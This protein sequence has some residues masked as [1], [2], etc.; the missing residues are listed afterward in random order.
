MSVGHREVYNIMKFIK[1]ILL[2]I[3][4][5]GA[6]FGCSV[7]GQS[8]LK[9]Y[10]IDV[11]T[12]DAALI[13]SPTNKYVL[14]DAGDD[15]HNYGDTVLRF[16]R[17]LGITHLDHIIAS[18]YHQD[19]IGG[20]PR[21]IYGL[22]GANT[23]DSILGWCYDR[24]D[25]YTTPAFI[26]YKNAIGT[27]RRTIGLGETLNLGGG[28][29]MFCVA[30]NGKIMN[31]DSVLPNTEENYRSL[32]WVIK[33]GRFRFYTGG[34]LVGYNVSGERDVETKVA[35]VI[36]K[37]DV[38]KVN[39]HGSR[40]SSNPTFLDSLRPKAAIISQGVHP[41]NNNHPHQEAL[42]R[43]AT[44]N[45]YIYQMNTNP[46][47]GTIPTGHGRIL[48]TTATIIVNRASY[49]INGDEYL[50]SGVLRDG[51]CLSI[52]SPPDTILEQSII[53]PK[54]LIKNWGNETEAFRIRF[55]ITPAYNRTQNIYDLAPND[56]MT[57]IFDTAWYAI[58]GVYQ[59]VCSTE[60]FG[61]TNQTNDKQTK[62][63]V[64]AFYDSEITD[65]LNPITN[66]AYFLSETITPTVIV[67][68][69]SEYAYPSSVK[70]YC[71]IR[72]DT[73]IYSD[74]M[75]ILSFPGRS[76]TITFTPLILQGLSAGVY[77]CSV[78]VVRDVD[79]VSAN[80][81][82]SFQFTVLNPSGISEKPNSVLNPNQ[83]FK[84][85]ISKLFDVSGRLIQSQVFS[86]S[87]DKTNTIEYWS[88]IIPQGI[89]FLHITKIPDDNQ[90]PTKLM[91]KL[92]ILSKK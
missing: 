63:L 72:N 86:T 1:F 24:G 18:H 67:K 59:V 32:V 75:E 79:L 82:R 91:R 20:I 83:R 16:L 78:A 70:V 50:L 14:I 48:N 34:D 8:R 6:N 52:L 76:D 88:K 62:S 45:I 58:R 90:Q 43:L 10:Q 35:P 53:T 68:D 23:N 9:I 4:A 2:L 39:H 15:R 92:I 3:T 73:A 40:N 41:V 47:G 13:V 33:Y 77:V 84:L 60:V 74:S 57:V 51:A 17:N 61:D 71:F 44:R 38:I 28:A 46:T 80:N 25:T 26:N 12:G 56:T 29:F 21:V 7:Y 37:V 54:A 64:V 19:H 27:K 11:N 55:R 69:N 87:A 5:L 89:Y 65:I 85:T 31:G 36:G 22:S 49:T 66:N 30:K 81:I 42:D